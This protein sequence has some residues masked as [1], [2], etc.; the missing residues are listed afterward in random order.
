MI[1]Q[2]IRRFY[3]FGPFRLDRIGHIL[4]RD[5]E[6]VPLTPKQLDI[7]LLLLE[8]RGR[9]VE[10]ERLMQEIWPDTV[11][12]E[13]NLTTNISTLRKALEEGEGQRYVQTLPRRGYRFV[14]QVSQ[15]MDCGAGLIVQEHA[16]SHIVIEQEQR[17]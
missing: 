4:L 14:G 3:E 5:G 6:V 13:G 9:V 11:V 7:L 12:E 1:S 15:V 16:Q 8:N 17:T 2:Q 10:K